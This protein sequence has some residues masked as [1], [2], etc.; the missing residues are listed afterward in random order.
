M[1][2]VTEPLRR[3]L[4]AH[5]Y[6]MLGSWDEAEDAVQETYLRAWRAWA[7]FENRSSVRT[8]MHRIATNVTL[9][10][11]AGRAR[12]ALPGGLAADEEESWI[13]PYADG[14][15]D[16]RLAL[17]AGLQT[18][19]PGQRAVLL[20]RDVL[21]FGAPEVAG[22]LGLTTGAVKSTLQRARARLAEA[23][24]RPDDVAEPR[25][26]VARR[27]L[28]AYLT[29][30]RTADVDGLAA[31]LRRDAILELVPERRW[32]DGLTSC[33]PVLAAAVGRPGDWRMEPALANGQ[34]AARAHHLGSPWGVAVLDCRAD[35][36]AGITV[37]TD[38]AL[39]SRFAG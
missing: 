14:G 22:M 12:R 7:R 4:T 19:T 10:L 31:M 25:S 17:I 3:E 9:S 1:T 24:P 27:Q 35:G 8:W 32:F 18:L 2:A 39:V 26:P 16:L 38:A 34:P 20:L 29:A 30:F 36:I 23:A 21:A 28:D 37:F 5:C 15:D 11:L 13:Q 33:L 6:R